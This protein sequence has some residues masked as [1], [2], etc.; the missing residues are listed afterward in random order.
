ME[1]NK[2]KI[3]D[4]C[5]DVELEVLISADW[6][7]ETYG[8]LKLSDIG[9]CNLLAAA[10]FDVVASDIEAS[11]DKDFQSV[12]STLRYRFQ[13]LA[14]NVKGMDIKVSAD[15]DAIHNGKCFNIYINRDLYRSYISSD[16][17]SEI[18]RTIELCQNKFVQKNWALVTAYSFD[19]EVPVRL[20]STEEEATA[21]LKKQFDEEVRISIEENGHIMG[22]TITTE[23]SDDLSYASITEYSL[24]GDKDITTWTVSQVEAG[25]TVN[26]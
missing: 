19:S 26:E 13:P 3:A 25:G 12:I 1:L 22:E 17:V 15:L 10:M 24:I 6:I 5:G 7:L 14:A 21:E 4:K 2:V 8:T 20:F 11:N 23:V 9:I 18:L 16:E